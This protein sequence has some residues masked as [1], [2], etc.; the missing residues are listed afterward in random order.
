MVIKRDIVLCIILSIITCGIYSL[1]WFVVLTDDTNALVGEPD[2]SGIASL[3]LTIITCGIYGFYWAYRNG[4]KIDR[5]KRMRNIPA[6]NGGILFL[7]L[8][9]FGGI[10]TYALIQNELNNLA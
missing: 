8:Y 10:I 1:Y 7:I 6:S 9:F 4:E 3:L 2:T 5:I